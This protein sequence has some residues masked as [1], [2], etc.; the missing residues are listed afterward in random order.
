MDEKEKLL[1]SLPLQYPW[2]RI[3]LDAMLEGD[4][5]RLQQKVDESEKEILARLT[6]LNGGPRDAQEVQAARDAL[7]GLASLKRELSDELAAAS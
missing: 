7:C 3:Y 5:G 2:Q 4:P 1:S 6:R